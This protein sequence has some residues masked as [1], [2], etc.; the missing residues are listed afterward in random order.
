MALSLFQWIGLGLV[1]AI[2]LIPSVRWFWKKFDSP[3]QG[4]LAIMKQREEDA[5]EAE[6]W[7]GIEAQVEAES[8]I[9]I[10]NDLKQREK[11]QRSGQ[12][13]DEEKS[14]DAWAKL[15][16]QAPIQPVERNVAPQVIIE[17]EIEEPDWELIEKMSKL[18]EPVE[19]VPDAPDLDKL[20]E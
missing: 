9:K 16:I 19:G 4:T 6:I 17:K 8:T 13:L 15:G 7:A 10:E 11:E 2:I 14:T 18:S 3:S 1:I 12:S 5:E 20:S